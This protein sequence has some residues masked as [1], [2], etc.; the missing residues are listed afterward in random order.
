MKRGL[1]PVRKKHRK[2]PGIEAEEQSAGRMGMTTTPG[3][4]NQWHSKGDFKDHDYL[5][6]HK[7]TKNES[8]SIKRKWWTKIRDEARSEMKEPALMLAFTDPKGNIKDGE[9]LVIITE[10]EFKN[11]CLLKT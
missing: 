2:N 4:G 11:L 5:V 3:S 6:E 7:S 10:K 1:K 9:G 8:I